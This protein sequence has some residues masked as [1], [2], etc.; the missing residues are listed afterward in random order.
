MKNKDEKFNKDLQQRLKIDMSYLER[1][2]DEIEQ[3]YNRLKIPFDAWNPETYKQMGGLMN[4]LY[5]SIDKEDSINEKSR[6]NPG[7]VILSHRDS[8]NGLKS[9]DFKLI[10]PETRDSICNYDIARFLSGKLIKE[11]FRKKNFPKKLDMDKKDLNEIIDLAYTHIFLTDLGEKI[12]KELFHKE[13]LDS[14]GYPSWIREQKNIE[15]IKLKKRLTKKYGSKKVEQIYEE[16]GYEIREADEICGKS[17]TYF[18]DG[19]E[20][21]SNDPLVD[22]LT[23]ELKC[24]FNLTLH[25]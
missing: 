1:T 23:H 2:V 20:R 5:G 16:I 15:H 3:E 6:E 21:Q 22:G 25:I 13:G 4:K 24:F 12:N 10:V 11:G 19:K 8:R 17:R 9:N 18:L 14:G 7:K